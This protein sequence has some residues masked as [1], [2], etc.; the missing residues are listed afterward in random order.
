MT[1]A[2]RSVLIGIGIVI[3]IALVIVAAQWD[4][5]FPPPMSLT[6]SAFQQNAI[7]PTTYT[8]DGEG[9]RP[10][11]TVKNLPKAT[12][13]LAFFI[14]DPDA[15]KGFTHWILYNVSPHDSVLAEDKNPDG[16][17]VGLN[18]A[19]KTGYQPLCPPSGTHHY[20]F[21]VYALD[22]LFKFVNPPDM[23]K[24]KKVMKWHVLAKA[25]LDATYSHH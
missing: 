8:C 15:P 10:P 23:Q 2:F 25:E 11:L 21:T 17:A 7:I 1:D 22:Q 16:S 13:S 20:Q 9:H 18:S 14:Y 5:I 3:C 24:L 6:S 12:A 4:R 19:N